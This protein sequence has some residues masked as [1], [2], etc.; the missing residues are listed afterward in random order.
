M[1][2]NEIL[3]DVI[4]DT[5]EELVPVPQQHDEAKQAEKKPRRH[6]GF[7]FLAAGAVCTA[8]AVLACILFLPKGG[9]Q[10]PDNLISQSGT[11]PAASSENG[12][13]QAVL[14][15]HA[16]Y[17]ELPPYPDE[18]GVTDWEAHADAFQEWNQARLKLRSQPEGYTDGYDSFV[19][20]STPVFLAGDNTENHVYS[21]LSLFLALGMAA[22]VSDGSTRQQ[23]LDALSQKNL[24]TLRAHAGSIWQANY[25]DDGMAK[26]VLANSL[27]TNSSFPYNEKTVGT[28]AEQY[29]ASVYAGDPAS[30]AYN[31]MMRDWMNEQTDNLLTDY[32]S[33]IRMDPQTV[34][35]LAST[36]NY[37]GKW[38][39]RFRKEETAPDTFHAP[40][41]DMTCDF[42]HKKADGGYYWGE[43]F[44]AVPLSLENNGEMR[45]ILPDE[46][47]TPEQ[48]LEDAE[49]I[50]FLNEAHPEN[51]KYLMVDLTVPKFDVS[52]G[53]DL[54]EGLE[55]LGIT[56]IFSAEA[57]DFSP[58]SPNPEGIFVSKAEQDTRV[59]IDEE[60]CRAASLTVIAYCGSAMPQDETVLRFD[61]PFLFEIVSE[62][63]LPL[64]VGVVNQPQG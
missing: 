56:D 5:A 58:L 10:M 48:L 4:G 37:S 42:L 23:I 64:F 32:V 39:S 6:G 24:K 60:G 20:R 43:H 34:L 61:R 33:D 29:Y 57:A 9:T 12:S 14:L 19:S 50:G 62:T 8:A 38:V 46:G 44:S 41:G 28:L 18:S 63:G 55:K 47:Y 22:E 49:L 17:P 40:S 25:M 45:L 36:V 52:S 31:A 3:L 53:I 26:C 13:A 1:K 59:T 16:V 21:P 35:L 7:P 2:N 30:E 54:K 51:Y 11:S 27:W 15:A